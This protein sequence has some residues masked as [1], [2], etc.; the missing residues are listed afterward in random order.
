MPGKKLSPK[1]EN[2]AVHLYYI[3][4]EIKWITSRPDCASFA[5]LQADAA[6]RINL[7]KLINMSNER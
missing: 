1:I 2:P 4:I 6:D 7:F 5:F 3:L